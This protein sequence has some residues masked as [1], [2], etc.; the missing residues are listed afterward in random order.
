MFDIKEELKKVPDSPGVYIMHDASDAILYV[1]KAVNLKRRVSQYFLGREKD[2]SPKIARMITLIDH[3]EYI[4]VKS[5]LEAL[6]LECNLIKENKPKYN[7][8][9]MDDKTYPY[10]KVTLYEK[11]P[12]VFLT[13][14]HLRDKSKYFGPYTNVTAVRETLKMMRKIYTYRT[15]EKALDGS[16]VDRP[17]LYSQIGECSGPCSGKVSPEEYMTGIEEIIKFFEGDTSKMKKKITDKM[18]EASA[19]MRF[20]EAQLYKEM[21]DNIDRMSQVQRVTSADDANRDVIGIA[22]HNAKA[23]AQIFFIRGGKMVGREHYY[24]NAESAEKELVMTQFLKQY[25]GGA[26]VV[27]REILLSE[28]IEDEELISEWLSSKAEVKVRIITPKRGT[29][30]KLVALAKTNAETVLKNDLEKLAREAARTTGAVAELGTLLGCKA[31]ERIESYDI[32]NINGFDQVGSM[33]VY[34]NGSPKRSDYR[35]FRIKTVQG[36]D[37]YACMREVLTRRF[38]HAKKELDENDSFAKLPDLIMMDGGRGQVN[39]ALEIVES[40]ALDIKICGMVK[41]DNHRTRALLYNDEE[42]DID[43]HGELFKLVTRIQDETHR[44]AIEY[45][46]LLRSKD[47]VKS[48]LD[49]IP[50]VGSV[51][52]NALMSHFESIDELKAAS[53][54]E[55]ESVNN[56]N[57]AAALS[58]Y[59]FFHK[60]NDGK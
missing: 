35:R 32:S 14:K 4:V 50:S 47:Q 6:V 41:D 11:F 42:L 28:N 31:P 56:M 19:D 13:R 8:M 45:H 21:R 57:K 49:D 48:I 29:K 10:V 58:V 40:F 12:R 54:E 15:C 5:E 22:Q 3:F 36:Q 38:E 43:S 26:A 34:E 27:P 16:A 17:C 18:Y 55:L 2:R 53:V 60:E 52:K 51:R 46:K 25:Y 20:E 30:E 33:V 9:L 44:F 59:E 24:I 1:G 23:I 7:T 39:I 37:D